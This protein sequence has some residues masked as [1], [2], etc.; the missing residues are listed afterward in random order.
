[1][2]EDKRYD[3]HFIQWDSDEEEYFYDRALTNEGDSSK[4]FLE[5]TGWDT[6]AEFVEWFSSYSETDRASFQDFVVVDNYS[7][8]EMKVFGGEYTDFF[9]LADVERYAR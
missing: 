1:M 9:M 4:S 8:E 7:G 6:F 5:I 2:T 3:A